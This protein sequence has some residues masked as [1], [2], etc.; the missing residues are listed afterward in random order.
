MPPILCALQLNWMPCHLPLRSP[1]SVATCCHARLPVADQSA[2]NTCCFTHSPSEILLYQTKFTVNVQ[3][4]TPRTMTMKQ[5]QRLQ[6]PR[7][8]QENG[9]RLTQV[10]WCWIQNGDFMT[11]MCCWWILT[12][13]I[14]PSSKST[15]SASQRCLVQTMM[16]RSVAVFV[17]W[18]FSSSSVVDVGSCFYLGTKNSITVRHYIFAASNFAILE[19]RN[20]TAF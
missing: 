6:L 19:C 10:G 20:F 12:V 7:A 9:N 11:N 16:N 18:L 5:R 14:H 1:T 15:I 3:L 17:C 4:I 2:M 13:C 8:S